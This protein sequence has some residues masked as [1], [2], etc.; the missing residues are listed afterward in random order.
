MR[1]TLGIPLGCLSYIF[2]LLFNLLSLSLLTQTSH[3]TSLRLRC[4]QGEGAPL[5]FAVR[6]EATENG[7][8]DLWGDLAHHDHM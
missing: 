7:V 2:D 4:A 8:Y 1:F 3:Y 6:R 5:K